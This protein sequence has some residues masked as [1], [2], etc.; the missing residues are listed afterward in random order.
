LKRLLEFRSRTVEGSD[1]VET[2]Q[3]CTFCPSRRIPSFSRRQSFDHPGVVPH[4]LA[5]RFRL[6][7]K[8]C[9]CSKLDSHS[10]KTLA[11]ARCGPSYEVDSHTQAS[12]KSGRYLFARPALSST[13]NPRL[14]RDARR[15][16]QAVC[17]MFSAS[18]F[19]RMSCAASVGTFLTRS[20]VR[21]CFGSRFPTRRFM[22]FALA[23]KRA[24]DY[25]AVIRMD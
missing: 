18:T 25:D 23:I 4:R 1:Q 6:L 10:I 19:S 8:Q 14:V 5:L 20:N 2:A 16:V 24:E 21:R 9:R 13:T 11:E 17:F 15:F 12:S 7:R 22:G 3:R